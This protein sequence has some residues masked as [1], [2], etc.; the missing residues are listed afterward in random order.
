MPSIMSTK[1]C[2]H[3][4]SKYFVN[5]FTGSQKY[6]E[7][8]TNTS[9]IDLKNDAAANAFRILL[10]IV[11]GKAVTV[12]DLSPEKSVALHHLLD[13]LSGRQPDCKLD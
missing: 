6:K 10:D 11:Y 12:D 2:L 3:H 4:R 5:I 13:L 1:S 7:S 8:E 9:T